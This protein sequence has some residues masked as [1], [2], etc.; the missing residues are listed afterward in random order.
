M[1]NF[2]GKIKGKTIIT[3]SCGTQMLVGCEL[4]DYMSEEESSETIYDVRE[5]RRVIENVP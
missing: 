4:T 2:A 5:G 1:Q 3:V